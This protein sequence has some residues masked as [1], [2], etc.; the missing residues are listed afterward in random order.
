MVHTPRKFTPRFFTATTPSRGALAFLTKAAKGIK[1]GM[2]I[3]DL[4]EALP[5][6]GWSIEEV[7][8]PFPVDGEKAAGHMKD[9]FAKNGFG[10]HDRPLGVG[11]HEEHP[12]YI[13]DEGQA[14]GF[15]Q[16]IKAFVTETSS[17]TGPTHISL[18]EV[19]LRN[20]G[21]RQEVNGSRWI[22]S[23]YEA[24]VG[25]TGWTVTTP[26]G[27]VTF[28]PKMSYSGRMEPL[29]E[30]GSDR[31]WTFAYKA[32]LKDLA[33]NFLEGMGTEVVQNVLKPVD[34]RTLENT[35][36]CP[37]CFGNTKMAK[38]RMMRHGW[39][40]AGR[41]QRGVSGLSWHT[42]PCFGVGYEPFEVSPEGTKDYLK[43]SLLPDLKRAED[44]LD[45][46]KA[47]PTLMVEVKR[48]SNGDTKAEEINES[49]KDYERVLASRITEVQDRIEMLSQERA[50]ITER[51]RTWEPRPLYGHVTARVVTRFL[52][53]QV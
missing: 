25:V 34:P 7:I 49:H 50:E 39:A 29:S 32:G 35:G 11:M 18:G 46:L 1:G 48:L 41:R 19:V 9:I 10:K 3:E 36:T 28:T 40:V 20:L 47:R 2:D 21:L 23:F 24:W 42:G 5:L 6:I 8:V 26:K 43:E 31:F 53:E 45:R 16:D 52:L 13:R 17:K 44:I 15:Y 51:I 27:G 37:A 38:G 12:M 30:K 22:L 4:R 14:K 33:K